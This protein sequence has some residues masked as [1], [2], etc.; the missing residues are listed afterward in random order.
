MNLTLVEL[1]DKIAETMDEVEI[2]EALNLDAWDLVEAFSD[3]IE[4]KYEVFCREL[5][6]KEEE[7]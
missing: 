1:K 2:L 3:V 4:S 7:Y 6:M 5:E